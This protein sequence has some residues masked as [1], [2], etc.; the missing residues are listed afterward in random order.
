MR[1]KPSG[2]CEAIGLPSRFEISAD[3]QYRA[4]RMPLLREAVSYT[5]PGKAAVKNPLSDGTVRLRA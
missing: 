1:A 4:A 2:R 3:G 5:V